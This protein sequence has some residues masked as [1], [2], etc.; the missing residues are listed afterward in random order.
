MQVLIDHK[1]KQAIHQ[2]GSVPDI[3]LCVAGGSNPSQIGFL[4]ELSPGGLTSCLESN[5]YSTVFITQ[6]YLQLW[7]QHPQPDRTRHI[8]FVSSAAAFV[9]LPG[10]IAYTPPKAAIRAFADT[11]R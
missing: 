4:A 6:M 9:G 10:Y 1:V 5:Y 2:Y 7:I 3:M 8:V 11:L